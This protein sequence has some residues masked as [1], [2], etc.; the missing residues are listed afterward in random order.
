VTLGAA[1]ADDDGAAMFKITEE[2]MFEL[3]MADVDGGA[4]R[5][6]QVYQWEVER[7][8]AGVRA[9]LG[10][11][12]SIV[13]IALAAFFEE[14]GRVG[15]RQILITAAAFGVSFGAVAY[16]YAKLRRLYGN[17]LESLRFF[18]VVQRAVEIDGWIP[19]RSP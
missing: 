3:A 12:A 14:V 19:S 11:A 9:A 13:A 8:L 2:R 4:D 16:Q 10:A 1:A 7:I 17:Y 15:P 18:A 6:E 5:I